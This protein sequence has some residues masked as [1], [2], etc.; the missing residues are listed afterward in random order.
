MKQLFIC[1]SLISASALCSA[2][3]IE[4]HLS[5]PQ[6][7]GEARFSY[8]FW[9]VYDAALYA[10]STERSV[11]PP[12]ALELTYL[13]KLKGRSIAQRSIDE[14]KS[15]GFSN[16]AKLQQWAY[17]MEAMFPDVK[18]GSVILGIAD[19]SNVSHFYF[20]GEKL[21][22]IED[23]D[24]TQRFFDIWLGENSTEP[25]FRDQLLSMEVAQ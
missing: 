3:V 21:G 1:F 11:K 4:S 15:Q 5:S 18:K 12:L 23:S 20:N 16:E 24:F 25:E 19:K 10:E 9:D 6:K 17:A 22:V 8:L 2:N 7:I 14:I 13:R